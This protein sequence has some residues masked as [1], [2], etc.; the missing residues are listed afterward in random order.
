MVH[1]DVTLLTDGSLVCDAHIVDA[2]TIHILKSWRELGKRKIC[3]AIVNNDYF[4]DEFLGVVLTLDGTV[5]EQNLE[6]TLAPHTLWWGG[7]KCAHSWRR[8]IFR[9]CRTN[10]GRQFV[11]IKRETVGRRSA[12]AAAGMVQER[13]TT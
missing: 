1:G 12:R 4:A 6:E 10:S 9:A 13:A 11:G 5:C 8:I 7:G 3:R 2:Q